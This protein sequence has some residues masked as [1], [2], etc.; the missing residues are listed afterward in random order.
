MTRD[1]AITSLEEIKDFYGDEYKDG[2]AFEFVALEEKE[3]EAIDMAIEALQE[4][5]MTRDEATQ[6]LAEWIKQ[7]ENHG[8]PPY[9]AKYKA[10]KLAIETLSA[11]AKHGTWTIAETY[12]CEGGEI[13]RLI[14]SECNNEPMAWSSKRLFNYCPNCGA[15]MKID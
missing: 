14:C 5:A 9:S 4:R 15:K 11:E 8:V 12:D 13:P 3:I 2:H 1:E 10:L 7:M 6:E